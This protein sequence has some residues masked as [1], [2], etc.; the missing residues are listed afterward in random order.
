MIPAI[1]AIDIDNETDFQIA[2]FS[3]GIAIAG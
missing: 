3:Y 2:E 1:R